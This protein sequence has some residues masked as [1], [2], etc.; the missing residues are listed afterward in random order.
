MTTV[1]R[2]H[3]VINSSVHHVALMFDLAAAA[4]QADV[5]RVFTFMN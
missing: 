5:T 3:R 2:V 1:D 4:Y